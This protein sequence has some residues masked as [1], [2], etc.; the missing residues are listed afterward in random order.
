MLFF[1]GLGFFIAGIAMLVL[2]LRT[3]RREKVHAEMLEIT[4]EYYAPSEYVSARRMPH[5]RIAYYHQG[6]RIET[7]LLLK[8]KKNNVGENILVTLD[9]KDASKATVY[10]PKKDILI[11]ILLLLLGI[12]LMLPG[13]LINL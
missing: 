2:F 4:N 11:T 3:L 6:K 12:G 13:V 7:K 8:A 1:F 5:G 10:H 9:P